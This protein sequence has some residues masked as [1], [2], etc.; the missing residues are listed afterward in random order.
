MFKEI[1]RMSA[2]Y[3]CNQI[4]H[5]CMAHKN[6]FMVSPANLFEKQRR[7]T[8]GAFLASSLKP[9]LRCNLFQDSTIFCIGFG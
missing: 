4:C 5:L 2:Y 7:D 3:K 9:G 1:F 6:T 8:L